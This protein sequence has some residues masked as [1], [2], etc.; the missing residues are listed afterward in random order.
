MPELVTGALAPP[1]PRP[2]LRLVSSCRSVQPAQMLSSSLTFEADTNST[3]LGSIDPCCPAPPQ[4]SGGGRRALPRGK[5]RGEERRALPRGKEREEE[6]R[7]LPRGKERE[8]ERESAR[9]VPERGLRLSQAA[10][11]SG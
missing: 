9:P 2:R 4:R 8:E 7:A 10:T 5:E 6:R 1:S 3:S 11:R